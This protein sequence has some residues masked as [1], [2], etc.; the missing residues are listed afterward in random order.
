MVELSGFKPVK[1]G[2]GPESRKID[3]LVGEDQVSGCN[4]FFQA[5]TGSSGQYM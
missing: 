5:A 2:V 4:F 1:K 3:K